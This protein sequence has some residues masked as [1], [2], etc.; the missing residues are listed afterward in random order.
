MVEACTIQH[1]LMKNVPAASTVPGN[2]G[3]TLNKTNG[4]P[5]LLEQNSTW[6]PKRKHR[7]C[8]S[9]NQETGYHNV[10]SGRT[11]WQQAK[12]ETAMLKLLKRRG[13]VA[14]TSRQNLLHRPSDRVGLRAGML[15]EPW[16][17]SS[18]V[19]FC[20]YHKT[21]LLLI[22]HVNESL[23]PFCMFLCSD[24]IDSTLP[25]CPFCPSL[26]FPPPLLA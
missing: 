24:F 17:F 21:L 23:W 6:G 12:W 2:E 20:Y 14:Q 19:L 16:C 8:S 11:K 10:R 7:E 1:L 15:A 26:S 9:E 18:L 3:T 13:E 22:T 4:N 25:T 5:P